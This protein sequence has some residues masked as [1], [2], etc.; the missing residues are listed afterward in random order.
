MKE[1]KGEYAY[2]KNYVIFIVR[3]ISSVVM[4]SEDN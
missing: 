4:E 3:R 2:E 1:L